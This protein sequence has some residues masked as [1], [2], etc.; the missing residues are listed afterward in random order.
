MSDWK[1]GEFADLFAKAQVTGALLGLFLA[2]LY[3]I[4]S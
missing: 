1:P 4:F 2:L 3:W